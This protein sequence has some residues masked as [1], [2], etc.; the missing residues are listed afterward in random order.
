[1]KTLQEIKAAADTGMFNKN[2]VESIVP[3]VHT[4]ELSAFGYRGKVPDWYRYKPMTEENLLARIIELVRH[5]FYKLRSKVVPN[6]K[7][8]FDE[9]QFM[10]WVLDSNLVSKIV[11]YSTNAL[12]ELLN[13]TA[14]TY[15]CENTTVA[16]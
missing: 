12:S 10:L 5:G 9:L 6:M 8:L 13:K 15:G 4:S 14:E 1:M 7:W 3:F 11:A 16:A 2:T